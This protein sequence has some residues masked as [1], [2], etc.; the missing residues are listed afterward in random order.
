MNTKLLLLAV[1][2]AAISSCTT[3][4]KSGQTP[5]D[6]YYSPGRTY[7]DGQ[8][9][10]KV[11]TKK[12]YTN[13]DAAI[14]MG[15]YDSRWRYLNDYSYSPYNYGF[16]H[17]YYY[18]P[19]FWPYPVYSPSFTTPSNPKVTTPRANNLSGYGPA[20][21]YNNTQINPKTGR[22]EPVRRYN[23]G[24]ANGSAVGNALRKVLGGSDNNTSSNSYNNS[25]NSNNNT[26][27]YT[28]SS[29]SSSSSSGSR[30]SSSSGQVSRPARN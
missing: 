26:R 2:V 5:D 6:V 14:R 16:N 12:V 20:R 3:L 15:I 22:I 17:G 30:S 29:S 9:E 28:P 11:E 4:Y 19:Y 27:S 18:N 23:N 8:Q 25:N 13:D 10:E 1:S 7:V 24:N 21:S